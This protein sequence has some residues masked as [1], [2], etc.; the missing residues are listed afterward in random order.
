M[1]PGNQKPGAPRPLV[2]RVPV[3]PVEAAVEADAVDAIASA[4]DV[5]VRG[6]LF[7]VAAQNAAD[8]ARWRVV[9]PMT[10]A[11]P[12][13]ARDS[14]NSKLW[15]RAK[16]EARDKAER[17]ALLAAV[18]R[19]ENEPVDELTVEDTRY[20]IVRVEEYVGLGREG[21]EQPRPTDP[22]PPVPDWSLQARDPEIDDGLVMDPDA[23]VTPT[24]AME[25]LAL[26][27]LAYAG[28]RFPAH[29][30]ADSRNALVTHPDVLVLP[31]TFAIVERTDTGWQP[32]GAPHATAH[33]A[34][35][36][37]QFGLLWTWPR[38]HGLIPFEADPHTTARTATEK[39]V[40][41]ADLAA[42]AAYVA[43]ADELRA[44]PRVNRV[45]LDDTVY[46]IGRT[47][48]LVRWGPDGP[49]PP[50]PSDIAG[51]DPERMHLVMDE[52]GNV[53]P[54]S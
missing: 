50:R 19:L 8:G 42:L 4:G 33:A 54:E 26:R 21:I 3:E 35:R 24:Q 46:Q 2:V 39:E 28:S 32:V 14:L 22:E 13:Q 7:G 51:H 20:R 6:P 25:Q 5:G 45:R 17:R 38:T 12:Q 41:A 37:L 30:L 48:R 9:V 52:D 34:R 31:A 23:P 36:S 11:C 27:D 53:L 15:F 44:A 40:S 49:E 16:D 29:V 18:T 47:R 1:E 43:A 10:A